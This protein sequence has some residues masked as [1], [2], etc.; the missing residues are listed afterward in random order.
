MLFDELL[1]G[2]AAAATSQQAP[3]SGTATFS[4]LEQRAA[5]ALGTGESSLSSQRH[6]CMA[7]TQRSAA[8]ASST[9]GSVVDAATPF[10]TDHTVGSSGQEQCAA[11][12]L[13]TAGGLRSQRQQ[14]MVQSEQAQAQAASIAGSAL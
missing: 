4:G 9:P 14:R 3:L 7:R 11:S 8:H 6:Q 10:S 12:S 1:D 5:S 13:D 2:C